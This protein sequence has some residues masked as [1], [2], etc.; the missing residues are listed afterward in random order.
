MVTYLFSGAGR[1]VG[2]V[3][4]YTIGAFI[5]VGSLILHDLVLGAPARA[6]A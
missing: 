1:A 5:V 6:R 3:A 4:D 2:H